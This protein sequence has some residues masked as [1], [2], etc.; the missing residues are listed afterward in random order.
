MYS[1]SL[2]DS[3]IELSLKEGERLRRYPEEGIEIIDMDI[4]SPVPKQEEKF[5]SCE[6]N[7]QNLQKL[8]CTLLPNYTQGG[9]TNLVSSSIVIDGELL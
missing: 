6:A 9:K 8:L 7:K 4:K 1:H 2:H 5:W 3:Y